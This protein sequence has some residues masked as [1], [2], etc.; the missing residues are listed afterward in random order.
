MKPPIP[1][2]RVVHRIIIRMADRCFPDVLLVHVPNGA[3]LKGTA[4]PLLGAA[5]LV[6]AVRS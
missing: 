5:V 3:N 4:G 6:G 1:S 2:E